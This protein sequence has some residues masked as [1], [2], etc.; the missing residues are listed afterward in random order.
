MGPPSILQPWRAH[1]HYAVFYPSVFDRRTSNVTT[2]DGGRSPWKAGMH[3]F[4][5]FVMGAAGQNWGQ[6][7]L[8][9]IQ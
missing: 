6:Q 2:T 8:A 1:A 3:H 9:P 7:Q 4:V 5:A